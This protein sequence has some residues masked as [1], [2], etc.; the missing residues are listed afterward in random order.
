MP[1]AGLAADETR[2]QP[3]SPASRLAGVDE[4][5]LRRYAR[6]ANLNMRLV[7][8]LPIADALR[9]GAAVITATPRTA[10]ALQLQ[11]AE[12]QRTAGQAV[13]PTPAI[14]DWDSWL[15]DLWRDV[16]FSNPDAPMLLSPLQE[17]ILWMRH[18]RSD[19]N[20]VL[21]P[22]SLAAL[23][24][25]AWSLLSAYRAHPARRH[26]WD[27]ADAERFRNWA[28]DFDRECSVRGWLSA[29]QLESRLADAPSGVMRLP[30]EL[31][32]IGFDRVT[33]AQKQFLAALRAQGV[34]VSEYAPPARDSQRRW[35]AASDPR[36]EIAAC[37]EW[38]R[39][40]L[41]NQPGARIAIVVPRVAESRGEVDRAFRRALL[42]GDDIRAPAPPLPFEFAL[43]HPLADVPCIRAALLLLRW[44]VEPL[45]E[46]EIAWLLL[47]GFIA[48]T[49]TNHLTV[50]RNDAVRRSAGSLL[51]RC[52]LQGFHDALQHV[53]SLHNLRDDLGALL[54]FVDANALI[55]QAR[56]PSACT[57]F[58]HLLLDRILWP[59]ER[60]AD[61]V[62]FQA[63]Q[64]WHRLLDDCAL[65]DFDGSLV[66]FA[67]FV[68][69]L[70]R[71]ARDTV[72]APE[73][74]NAP[75][76]I[77]SPLESSGQHFDAIWFMGADDSAWPLRGRPHPLLPPAIQRQFSMPHSSPDADWNLAH[78]VTARLLASAPQLVFSYARHKQ[79][80]ELRPSPLVAALFPRQTVPEPARNLRPSP[81]PAVSALE[82][83]PDDS[84]PMPWPR[85]RAAGGADVLRSQ[86]ACPFQAFATRRLAAEPLDDCN[87]GFTSAERGII[88]H[89]V[90]E[91][92]YSQHFRSREDIVTVTATNRL[93][94][95]LNPHIDAVLGELAPAGPSSAWQDAYL[96]AEKRRLRARL[97][98]WLACEAK[99]Q[100]FTVEACEQ[101]LHN[102]H[103]GDLR[104]HLRA[105]RIDRLPDGTR[106]LIDYKTGAISPAAWRGDRPDE[107][108]LPLYAAYGNVGNLGGVLLARIR[109]GETGFDGRVRDARAQL[110]PD[111]SARK[112]LVTDP[113]TDAMRDEWAR[114]LAALAREFLRGESSVS[115]R[116][117]EVCTHCPLP[118]LCRKAELSLSS[119]A[120]EELD[121]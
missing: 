48:A 54:Q 10:R 42:P 19:A 77:M 95:I 47:S 3:G 102:V 85:E 115:P 35:I 114:S 24:M 111:I 45:P 49:V 64:R 112:A 75:I 8:V 80:A 61:S 50:A 65:L 79:D 29:A 103:V 73:S 17:R 87:W 4:A 74:H 58:V 7:L 99:R 41:G 116:E 76:Q 22:D 107:P 9:R 15:R 120:D 67:E 32:L 84:T 38:A 106:L 13:W 28:Q 62:Q 68:S 6:A 34:A 14:L 109:A 5:G 52:S 105:D 89:K 82:P 81:S 88:L 70:E 36:E 92:L 83:L 86:A 94:A 110:Q 39:N 30:P 18:Q 97:A 69:L 53:P 26:S 72:F 46:E 108:Q 16:A 55:R 59:G 98:E 25:E 56:Q 113:Y 37:A 1:A 96:A 51:P 66:A 31:L 100:P 2:H 118:A 63:L 119:S 11:Y 27:Q 33:P 93:P 91:R 121:A 90:L 44:I 23:A 101:G 40:L 104:L 78:A 117:P 12:D 43:G 57:E 20:L 21:W 71:Q 60:P